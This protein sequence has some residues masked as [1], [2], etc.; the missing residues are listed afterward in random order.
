MADLKVLLAAMPTADPH[1]N[2]FMSILAAVP[3]GVP[4]LFSGGCLELLLAIPA[5]CQ[6]QP[7]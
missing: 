1:Q 7:S 2:S 3:E 6:V 5:S 4:Y